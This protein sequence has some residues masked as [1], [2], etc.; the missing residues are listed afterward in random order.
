MAPFPVGGMKVKIASITQEASPNGL[1]TNALAYSS[2]GPT[3]DEW[4]WDATVASDGSCAPVAGSDQLLAGSGS[5]VAT[6][7]GE[8]N[9]PCDNVIM[10]QVTGTYPGISGIVL[11]TR[12]TLTQT[13]YLRWNNTTT[14]SELTCPDCTLVPSQAAQTAQQICTVANT[15]SV[16]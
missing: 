13:A 8:L 2:T 4:E 5:L 1:P 10:V 7:M 11:N 9:V 6:A 14:T 12:P 15:A 3:Y 16:N